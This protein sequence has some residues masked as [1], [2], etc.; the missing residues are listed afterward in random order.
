MRIVDGEGA[1]RRK[2][3]VVYHY[4]IVEKEIICR[5]MIK[6]SIKLYPKWMIAWKQVCTSLVVVWK[7]LTI[8][9]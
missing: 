6:R 8:M 1:R 2:A 4:N 5:I 3:R 7:Q 9:K